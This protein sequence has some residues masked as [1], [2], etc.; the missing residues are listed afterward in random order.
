MRRRVARLASARSPCVATL[1]QPPLLPSCATVRK[2]SGETRI[3][4][5]V[6]QARTQAGPPSI[7]EH[8]SHLI[9]FLGVSEP[10]RLPVGPFL[11]RLA[12]PGPLP[13]NSHAS[14]PGFFGGGLS[15]R[16]TP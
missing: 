5:P 4:A 6:G 13:N 16:I 3:A 8:M 10:A 7:P 11:V 2:S 12:G 9:A 14:R 1:D 15:M